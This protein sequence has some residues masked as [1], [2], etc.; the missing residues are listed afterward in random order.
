MNAKLG[1]KKMV[2]FTMRVYVVDSVA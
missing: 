1:L 2:S